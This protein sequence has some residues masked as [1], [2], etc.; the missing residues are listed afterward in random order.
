M[1]APGFENRHAARVRV[2]E[3]VGRRD[4]ADRFLDRGNAL[5]ILRNRRQG[6]LMVSQSCEIEREKRCEVRCVSGQVGG[7]H[8]D[9]IGWSDL[10]HSRGSND[11]GSLLWSTWGG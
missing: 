5:R 2:V 8:G 11:S 10:F 6:L 1:H 3:R 4:A 9:I 7:V